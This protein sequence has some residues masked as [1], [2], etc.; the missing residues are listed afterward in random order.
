[1]NESTVLEE[2]L[3]ELKEVKI[4]DRG[5]KPKETVVNLVDKNAKRIHLVRPQ[6]ISDDPDTGWMYIA[7]QVLTIDTDWEIDSEE[8]ATYEG[9]GTPEEFIKSRIYKLTVSGNFNP[10]DRFMK[11]ASAVEYSEDDN[12]RL[13]D[14]EI[15]R[16]S[17]GYKLV[18][19]GKFGSIK[20]AGGS[21][22]EF[23]QF[24]AEINFTET[25]KVVKLEKNQ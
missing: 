6:G 1:M 25:P 2:L 8:L 16:P 4:E 19:K 5:E 11:Y 13:L 3:E 23:E 7:S 15:Y 22:D 21:A 18:G 24:E 10:G 9:D 14:I 17:V 12:A 20:T